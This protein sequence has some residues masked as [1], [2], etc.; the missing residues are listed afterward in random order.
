MAYPYQLLQWFTGPAYKAE[1]LVNVYSLKIILYFL[2]I[3]Y[4]IVTVWV[5][6]PPQ[7]FIWLS[8]CVSVFVC[9]SL[10]HCYCLYLK[11]F[12]SDFA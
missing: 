10:S 2:S 7:N 12:G 3:I 9:V 6:V 11:C 4:I 5:T 8:V 1:K